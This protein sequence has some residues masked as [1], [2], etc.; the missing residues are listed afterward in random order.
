VQVI[1]RPCPHRALYCG[2]GEAHAQQGAQLVHRALV[3]E[4]L[5]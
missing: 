2:V 1:V 5:I 4:D 3:L